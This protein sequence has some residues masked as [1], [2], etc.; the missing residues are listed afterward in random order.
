[1]TGDLDRAR[2]HL[3]ALALALACATE[4]APRDPDGNVQTF[5]GHALRSLEPSEAIEILYDHEPRLWPWAPGCVDVL[6][7]NSRRNSHAVAAPPS[8]TSL[9]NVA[10]LGMS[11]L[12]SV[13][14]TLAA[15]SEVAPGDFGTEIVWSVM[16][17]PSL[18]SHHIANARRDL[19]PTERTL[20]SVAFSREETSLAPWSTALAAPV[21]GFRG[22]PARQ[23][24]LA[25]PLLRE[26]ALAGVHLLDANAGRVTLGVHATVYSFLRS[27]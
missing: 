3:Q 25:H 8:M 11:A 6:W 18:E 4:D 12:R 2:Q 17:R 24:R 14:G 22:D 20:W 23:L 21:Y 7:M 10:K 19:R 5:L 26:L 16:T 13:I 27:P 9:L 15:L 1:M